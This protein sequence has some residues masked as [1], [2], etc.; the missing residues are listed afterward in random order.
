MARPR[1]QEARRDQLVDATCRAIAARG[2]AG[3][4]LK[5]IADEADLTIG[6]VLYYYPSLEEL[7]VEVHKHALDLFYWDRVRA[8]EQVCDPPAKLRV[9]VDRGVPAD[10]A[11]ATWRVIYELHAAAAR[12]PVQAGLLATLWQREVSLYEAILTEGTAAG[13]FDLRSPSRHIAETAVA[14]EDA[15]DLHL[16]SN[17]GAV[18]RDSAI[19]RILDY[20][21]L[22]TGCPLSVPVS[23]STG[24]RAAVQQTPQG[25]QSERV[26]SA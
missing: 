13:D 22:V 21:T 11:S 26:Q 8:T 17:N 25:G 18:D 3:L 7:L 2:L 6:S 9:A 16:T 15:F 1:R 24:R 20:L 19:A 14:L 5:H 12:N 4:R 10:H 23:A